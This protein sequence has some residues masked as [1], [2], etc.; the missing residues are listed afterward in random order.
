[1]I[2]EVRARHVA[3]RLRKSKISAERKSPP[4][5]MTEEVRARYHHVATHLQKSKIS[6]ERKSP[7]SRHIKVA[8]ATGGYPRMAPAK[9]VELAPEPM[10]SA[11]L[12][13]MCGPYVS[14]RKPWER[15]R[16]PKRGPGPMG[17]KRS[18]CGYVS[19]ISLEE[20]DTSAITYYYYYS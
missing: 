17:G 20:L 6:A 10:G 4:A 8:E 3:T 1:M 13:L 14:K 7:L 2:E 15:M 11:P 5:G 19:S 12:R 16:R 18:G 9:E